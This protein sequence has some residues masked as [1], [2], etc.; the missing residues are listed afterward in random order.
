MIDDE[1]L[2]Q[3]KKFFEQQDV[4]FSVEDSKR[5]LNSKGMAKILSSVSKSGCKYDV[6]ESDDHNL[7]IDL[8]IGNEM[9]FFVSILFYDLIEQSDA[10]QVV[11]YNDSIHI[12]IFHTG[13]FKTGDD[14]D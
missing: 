8:D 11:V 5:F 14:F 2:N 12:F 9:F 13:I 1:T 4:E 3:L 10:Y 6:Y 7:I